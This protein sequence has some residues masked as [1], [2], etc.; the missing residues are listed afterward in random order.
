MR[1]V[2][3]LVWIDCEMTGLDFQ[4]D[5]LL[6]VAAVVTDEHLNVIAEGPSLVIH[7]PDKVLEKMGTWCQKQHR[8]S[9]LFFEVQQSQVTLEQAQEQLMSFLEKY[10]FPEKAPLCGNSVWTDRFF[11]MK[12]LPR[13]HEFL[14]YRVVDVSSIKA[15]AKRWYGIDPETAFVKKEIHRAL[16]D[17]YESINELKYY[18]DTIF[19]PPS[20]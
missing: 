6:E 13:V 20:F 12:E 14:H 3:N 19:L 5:V 11:L 8:K 2:N 9:N 17:I 7:R 4:D 10:C 16:P 15:L 1:H 18:R